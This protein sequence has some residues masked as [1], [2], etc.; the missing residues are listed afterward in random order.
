MTVGEKIKQLRKEKG[1]SADRLAELIGKDRATV[2][3]YESSDIEKLP[4]N[5]LE[6][7]AKALGTTPAALMGWESSAPQQGNIYMLP[8]FASTAAGFGLTAEAPIEH[9]PAYLDTPSERERYIWVKAQGDS[10]SPLIDDGS[11]LLIKKQD[12][13]ESGQ[14]GAAMIDGTQAVIRR[15]CFDGDRIELQSVN[16]YYPPLRFEARERDRVRVLGIVKKISK[17]LG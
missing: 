2:Y 7:L 11:E 9:I 14:I 17:T 10:M 13:I 5:V 8:L 1:M 15:I 12:S 16:P 3:R 4:T 6:P